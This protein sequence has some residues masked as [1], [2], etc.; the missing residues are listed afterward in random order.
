[1]KEAAKRREG[2]RGHGSPFS[3]VQPV[4]YAGDEPGSGDAADAP[5]AVSGCV[6]Q[7]TVAVA[8]FCLPDSDADTGAHAHADAAPKPTPTTTPAPTP[9]P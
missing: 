5:D 1:V 6:R 7:V 3:G 8:T 4:S 2:R 9:T